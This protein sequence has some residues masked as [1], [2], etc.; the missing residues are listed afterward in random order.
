MNTAAF[1]SY[2]F[3][4][5]YTPGPNNIMAMTNS[6]KVGFRKGM[7][8][9]VGVFLGFLVDMS[10]LVLFTSLLFQYIPGIAPVM[11]WI[12]AAYIL[13]L[14]FVT[15]RDK[16]HAQKKPLLAP[17]SLLSGVVMQLVN[18]KV[19]LFGITVMS[20]FL[21]PTIQSPPML[22]G[23]VVFLAAVAFS[24]TCCWALFGSLFQRAFREHRKL[25]NGIMA[26]LLV[27][28]AVMCLR[29]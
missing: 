25:V 10:L 12:G 20:T 18:V 11:K 4:T 2:V 24:A 21:L 1:L 19:I 27:Y 5:T 7:R 15:L 29:G 22:A 17:G 6:A 26:V 3:L 16:P 9:C 8:F 28:C 23:A 13:Y 14:A